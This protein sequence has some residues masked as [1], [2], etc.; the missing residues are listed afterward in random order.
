[1]CATKGTLAVIGAWVTLIALLSPG[2]AHADEDFQAWRRDTKLVKQGSLAYYV[3]TPPRYKKEPHRKYPL[4]VVLHWS[5]V[6]GRSYLHY[7]R[8]DGDAHDVIIAAPNSRGRASWLAS[9]GPNIVKM[10]KQ[11]KRQYSVDETKIWL[12]GYSAGGVFVYHLLFRYPDLFHAVL[13]IGGRVGRHRR[14][15]PGE[16]ERRRTRVC[17]F[18]GQWDANIKFKQAEKDSRFLRL[19]GYDVTFTMMEKFGH[20]IPRTRGPEFFGCL[21]GSP[22]VGPPPTGPRPPSSAV[23][24]PRYSTYRIPSAGMSRPARPAE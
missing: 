4:L 9:D 23:R 6:R 12:A 15:A 16:R 5:Y 1:M 24:R 3:H 8:P 10:I 2:T 21:N 13:P 18:H 22:L 19:L 11:I 14:E 20:W 17:L 7:W